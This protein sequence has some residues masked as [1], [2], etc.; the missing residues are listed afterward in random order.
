MNSDFVKE[1][2]RKRLLFMQTLYENTK[3]DSLIS[4]NI[5]E[6][7]KK[8]GFSQEETNL[9]DDYLNSHKYITHIAFGGTISITP[10]GVNFV[11]DLL[12]KPKD[13]NGDPNISIAG[14]A[15]KNNIVLG[16]NNLIINI[17]QSP[18]ED[19]HNSK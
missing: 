11:E 5:W 17:E 12:L 13:T 8:L 2:Q 15:I 9:V 3:G 10:K 16:N 4:A 19:E 1:M 18:Q 7:G 6:L 14:S